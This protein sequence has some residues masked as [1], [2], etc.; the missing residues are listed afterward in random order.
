MF[1]QLLVPI[2]GSELTKKA[3]KKV[4]ALAKADGSQ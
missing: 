1:K 4:A 3:L 2:D